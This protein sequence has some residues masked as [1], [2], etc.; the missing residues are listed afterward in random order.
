MI[1]FRAWQE[2]GLM[3]IRNIL[4]SRHFDIHHIRNYK[5]T[6]SVINSLLND[7]KPN[8][9]AAKRILTEGRI[10]RA[11]LM[12]ASGNWIIVIPV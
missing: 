1:L 3:D 2:I 12:D 8:H 6:R 5:N 4:N 11:M 10:N 9:H 7:D